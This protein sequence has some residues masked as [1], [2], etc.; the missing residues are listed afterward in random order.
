MAVKLSFTVLDGPQVDLDVDVVGHKCSVGGSGSGADREVLGLPHG[1]KYIEF[2]QKADVWS[3][4][5]FKPRTTL[6]NKKNLKARNKL[7][8][9]DVIWLP[10]ASSGQSVRLKLVL[11]TVKQKSS[12][13]GADLKKINPMILLAGSIYLLLFLGG[14]L[15]FSMSGKDGSGLSGAQF[16]DVRGKISADIDNILLEGDPQRASL[17]D[18]PTNFQ[19]LR[20]F[21]LSD[22]SATK[23]IEISETFKLMVERHFSDAWRLEQ[24]KRPAEARDQYKKVIAIMG[25]YD[26]QT[27]QFALS[28]LGRLG[29][30]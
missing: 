5:E 21:L 2:E 28:Q 25:G 14:M 11:E 8:N 30:L 22:I 29:G 16:E 27:T 18:T 7:R 12:A 24:Q 19:E 4:A 6:L 23:K 1:F 20:N 3:V 9:G 17:T 10:S 15:Y 13:S 26:L